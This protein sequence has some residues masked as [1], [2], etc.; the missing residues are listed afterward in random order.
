MGG[1]D[2]HSRL[3]AVEVYN[4]G[5]NQ[6]TILSSMALRRSDADACELNGHIYIVGLC[7]ICFFYFRFAIKTQKKSHFHAFI[8]LFQAVSMVA[9]A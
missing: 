9:Y 6:W 4:P 8:F 3:R 7:S 1:H 2:G 5:T